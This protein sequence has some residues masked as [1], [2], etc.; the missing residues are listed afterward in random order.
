MADNAIRVL[1]LEG[2]PRQCGQAHGEALREQ[3][4]EIQD[5]FLAETGLP[6]A[7][8][9]E[10][11]IWQM[12][13]QTGFLE[14]ARRWT[15]D[16][17]EEV[18]GI[19]EGAGV[20]RG[21]I[22]AFQHQDEMIN[23]SNDLSARPSAGGNACTSL[24]CSPQDGSPAVLAQNL[25]TPAIYHGRQ[26]LLK[27]RYRGRQEQVLA[28]SEPG[29]V[30]ICGL[31]SHGVGVCQNTLAWQLNRSYQGVAAMLVARGLLH[32]P[33]LERATAFLKTIPHA[34][35]IN[36]AIGGPEEVVDYE[37]SPNQQARFAP[38][39]MPGRVYHTNH[40]LVNTDWHPAGQLSQ[41]S[42]DYYQ[43]FI[44]N[45]QTRLEA[46]RRRMGQVS[47]PLTVAAVQD[48]LA[49]HDSQDYPIC[50]HVR[51]EL[52]RMGSCTNNTLIMELSGSPRLLLT[53]EP[54][55]Q[56]QYQEFDFR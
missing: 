9:L 51:P 33:D 28:V 10:A 30:G 46:L 41:G 12:L 6:G 34:S 21:F 47:G 1:D 55:C 7:Q 8:A 18:E 4:R 48:L 56:R 19:C 35:G 29:L 23:L 22:W 44:S 39:D 32:Q 20:G 2:T 49:S 38:V 31:N 3:I 40:P 24:G 36:Y 54:P 27:V 5:I 37:C 50:R 25:D 52:G 53:S 43:R 16:L 17:A 42:P 11:M 15:P 26:V 45:S 14:S 13:G